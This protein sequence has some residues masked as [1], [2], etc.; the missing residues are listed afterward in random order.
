M[1]KPVFA[2]ASC[3][4]MFGGGGGDGDLSMRC[5]V[6]GIVNPFNKNPDRDLSI[7]GH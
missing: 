2:L 4:R 7:V 1:I 3:K 5:S 6:L